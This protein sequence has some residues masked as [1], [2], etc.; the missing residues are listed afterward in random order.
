MIHKLGCPIRCNQCAE[1]IQL[2]VDLRWYN[3]GTDRQHVCS[4]SLRLAS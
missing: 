3:Y 1:P 2:G 4:C